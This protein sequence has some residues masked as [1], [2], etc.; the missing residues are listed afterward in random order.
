MKRF[1]KTTLA[2]TPEEFTWGWAYWLTSI[3]ALPMVLPWANG[4]LRVPLNEAQ[5]NFTYYFINFLALL[6]I[7]HDYLGRGMKAVRRR[8][9]EFCQ[10]VILGFC[11]YKISYW[12]LSLLISLVFPGFRNLNDAAVS[13]MLGQ[14]YYLT[15]LGI[16][17]LV[18][19]AEELLYRGLLFGSMAKRN[20]PAAYAI[21]SVLFA[22]VHVAAYWQEMSAL[23]FLLS[24]VQYLPAGIWLAWSCTKSGSIYSS[25]LIHAAVNLTAVGILR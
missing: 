16:T 10:S 9:W 17:V 24:L 8:P 1:T 4:F 22:A 19:L 18:P 25:I 15:V 20:L 3:I 2:P 11:A 14:N 7:F 13:G 5:L 23:H 6:W 12:L 21:S